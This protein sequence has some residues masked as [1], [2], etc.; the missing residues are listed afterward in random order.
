MKKQSLLTAFTAGMLLLAGC[1]NSQ[2]P[3]AE[4]EASS[5]KDSAKAE[6][7]LVISTFGLNQD[8]VQKI[9]MDPF[10]KD[11]N[12]KVTLE[13]GNA[14]ERLTKLKNDKNAN[15]DVIELSQ[16]NADQGAKD[17]L[18]AKV[19]EKE[20]PNIAK[21][22]PGAKE[23]YDNGSGIP[24][25]V[26][27]IGIIYDREALGFEIKDW[28]DLWKA[29]LKG[30]VA[31]PELST[32]FGPAML[33]VAS[34]YK[35]AKLEDDKGKAAF[36]ALKELKP[37]VV[38][39]Y[40]KSS[41]LA[42]M[43]QAGEVQVAVVAD[44]AQGMIKEANPKVSFI[45]P[46]SGTYANYNTLNIPANAKNKELAYKYLNWRISKDLEL[47]T[48]EGFNEA[49]VNKDVVLKPE[50]AANKTYGPVA[51]KAKAMNT[52]FVDQNL[53]DWLNQWNEVLN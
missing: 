3:T 52:K 15:I 5:S 33:Y 51:V 34:D 16:L 27:S 37:N 24:Y 39:T 35:G 9:V 13:V 25:A 20:V 30:K 1:G 29:E 4:K 38:K 53:A 22:T 14:S 10:A 40:A 7:S 44:F 47:K 41:D 19:T 18:F 8:D 17:K 21:L 46:E 36:E 45:V 23:V 42:N 48:A 28:S 6:S 11:N 31:I 12:A 49:P 2:A 43:F 26:N 32:T 50:V